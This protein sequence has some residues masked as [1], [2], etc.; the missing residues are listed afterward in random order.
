VPAYPP[1]GEVPRPAES[2]E[3]HQAVGPPEDTSSEQGL[4]PIDVSDY[5]RMVQ[6]A[7]DGPAAAAAASVDGPRGGVDIGSGVL[8]GSSL[9]SIGP[10]ITRRGSL[11]AVPGHVRCT[12]TGSMK[13]AEPGVQPSL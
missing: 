8:P 10:G 13:P 1:S 7:L 3:P 2:E 11:R 9:S 5:D 12:S 6:Q 4:E